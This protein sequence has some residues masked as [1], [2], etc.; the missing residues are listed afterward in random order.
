MKKLLSIL[1]SWLI[2]LSAAA[3]T[4]F[5]SPTGNG[6][7]LTYNSPCSLRDGI[8][9]I[10]QPGDTL[11][12]LGGQYDLPKTSI[13]SKAGTPNSRI[14]IGS[15]P[16]EYA[17]LDFRNVSYG[18][19]G[20]QLD[21]NCQYVHLHRFALRYSG[22]NNLYNE[23]SYCLFEQL[24][25][26]GSAD[27]G[28]Q[29]KNGGNNTILNC[30]SH[31]NFDYG[32]TDGTDLTFTGADY[33]GN[34]DGFADKQFTGAPNTY[35]GCR[36][37]NNSDDG[38]DFY[39]RVTN[40]GEM[41]IENCVCYRNGPATYDMRNHARYQTD[42]NFFDQFVS[43][44]EI[45]YDVD[46]KNNNRRTLYM[47]FDLEH[48]YNF[49]NGNGFKIGGNYT[50]NDVLLHHCLSVANTVKGFDQNNNYGVMRIYN[51]TGYL[52]GQNFGFFNTNGGTLYLQNNVSYL[53][54]SGDA[55]VAQVVMQ[56]NHNSW[57]T[58]GISC[59]GTDFQSLD[60]TQILA[61]R[62]AD[63][64]LMLW[65]P[66][67]T[68]LHLSSGS[69]MINAGVNVGLAYCDA[70][71]EMGC[72]EQDGEYHPAEPGNTP[73]EPEEEP[74]DSARY[75]VAFV[76]VP[77]SSEDNQMLTWLRE[78]EDIQ[79]HIV[80]A[81]V[82]GQDFSQ[83]DAIVIGPKPSSGAAAFPALKNYAKPMV[84]LKPWLFKP[85]V[86]GWGTA[87]NTSDL[88]ISVSDTN[89]PLFRHITLTNNRINL[90]TRCNE[91]AV[92]AI[93]QWDGSAPTFI[94]LASPVGQP[95]ASSVA[96][97]GSSEAP[98]V[99]LGTSEYSTAYL[100]QDGLQL[101]ENAIYYVLGC[102]VPEHQTSIEANEIV[103]NT[104]KYM[105]KQQVVIERC[106]Q[107][108]DLLGRNITHLAL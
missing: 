17:I 10:S 12:L 62:A 21:K 52:N 85:S 1:I 92:T 67:G 25:I 23:G 13:N 87:I 27:T 101:I 99:M 48:F 7:G 98:M 90:F 86:W 64:S 4:Y 9:L 26:Y 56:N 75:Q 33:G 81:T 40:G 91:N 19:R 37:W 105:L 63:G 8:N 66:S 24:D 2:A 47:T 29:M 53:G 42:R 72:F 34:A 65:N 41:V 49:G 14:Y 97:T 76:T 51:N 11:Y 60:T 78:S 43:G 44:K 31:D 79:I 107:L 94:N 70:A 39:Q 5:A 84:V 71:P 95:T 46:K 54:N 102:E 89:H 59:S 3:T 55:Q 68:L 83:Y 100:T 57:N 45:S 28:C 18:T 58:A 16:G 77:N 35:I 73:T 22:K 61:P 108:Y 74:I 50:N 88:S 106:G 69:R 20:L 104:R 96:I 103:P 6:N 80:N 38:W 32:N 36:A 93:S 15:F 30:D 82:A